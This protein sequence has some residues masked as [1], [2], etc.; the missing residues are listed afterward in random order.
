MEAYLVHIPPSAHC[1]NIA[2][3]RGEESSDDAYEQDL[4]DR[5]GSHEKQ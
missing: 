3:T 2:V 4:D 1:Q 5:H